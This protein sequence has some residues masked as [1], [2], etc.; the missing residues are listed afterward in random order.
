MPRLL[1]LVALAALAAH[2]ALAQTTFTVTNTN[3][4]GAGSLRQALT[5]ANAT[6]GADVIAFAIPGAGPHTLQPLTPLPQITDAVTLDGTTQPGA[7][8]DAW[9]A[10]LQIVL[11][12]PNLT[13]NFEHGLFI[14][15][16]GSTLRGLVI[17]GFDAFGANGIRIDGNGNTVTCSYLGTDP[18]GTAARPNGNGIRLNGNDNTV[19]GAS[20]TDRVLISGNQGVGLRISGSGN[21]LL[22]STVGANLTGAAALPNGGEGVLTDGDGTVIGAPGAGNL[23][24]GN[25]SR[26][27]SIGDGAGIVVQGNRIG[28]DAAGTAAMGNSI[29]VQVFQAIG[30]VI[31]GADPGA[32]N[33]I[34]GNRGAGVEIFFTSGA[35]VRG[36]WIGTDATGLAPLGNGTSGPAD[37]VFLQGNA[38][39][40]ATGNVIGGPTEAEGNVIVASSDDGLG[41]TGPGV[42]G[43]V[44]QNNR[45]GVGADGQTPLPNADDGIDLDQADGT[46]ILGNT[47]SAN[48]ENG[49]IVDASDGVVVRGNHIGTDA[50]GMLARG[51]GLSGILVRDGAAATAIGGTDPGDGNTIAYNAEAAIAV[52]DSEGARISRNR[53]FANAGPA[54]DLDDDGATP[55]DPGDGDSGPNRLQNSPALGT[56]TGDGAATLSVTY[57]VDTATGNATYPLTVEFFLA[58]A[59]DEEGARFL[60]ADT[61]AAASAQSDRTAMLTPPADVPDGARIVATATD[62]AGNTSEFSASATVSGAV[63]SSEAGAVAGVALRVT[64]SPSSR[65]G[66]RL[67]V[68]AAETARISVLDALGRE[69]AVLHEGALAA[70][71]HTWTVPTLAAGAYGVRAEM[72]S[73]TVV[74][75]LVVVR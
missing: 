30:L 65:P 64:A 16:D 12:G 27:V 28:T 8:C 14:T 7:S 2:P 23:I 6:P 48:V 38:S 61:Y 20:E 52:R 40:P 51:N 35:A 42:I 9:P 62:A 44:I 43:T 49:I 26:G 53:T 66:V 11:D 47:I 55:N 74:R 3:D 13:A 59:D 68:A 70:G 54:V 60:G 69:I 24:S 29:G 1:L 46:T 36:N 73:G 56:A 31:G 41:T 45:I 17:G 19:G 67:E 25:T 58:D 21:T 22:G 71:S 32:R 34:S 33:L 15:G 18:S 5:D 50:G 10:T 75:R 4:D 72:G 57:S 37:G 63:V 39:V